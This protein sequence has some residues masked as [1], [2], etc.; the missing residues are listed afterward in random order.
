VDQRE[1][2]PDRVTDI[3]RRQRR[4]DRARFAIQT[5]IAIGIAVALI[6]WFYLIASPGCCTPMFRPL[7]FELIPWVAWGGPVIGLAWM[8]RLAHPPVEDGEERW[9]FRQW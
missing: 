7:L 4:L 8:I 3:E 1:T 6:T 2:T 9:R 5:E